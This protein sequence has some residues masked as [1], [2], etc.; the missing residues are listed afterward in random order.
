MLS[1]EMKREFIAALTMKIRANGRSE[2]CPM[3]CNENFLMIDACLV[4]VLQSDVKNVTLTGDY[5]PTL[6]IVCDNCGFL[7]QHAVGAL[8]IRPA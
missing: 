5:I 7:S 2:A 4:N 8:G 6:A 1:E 3:C